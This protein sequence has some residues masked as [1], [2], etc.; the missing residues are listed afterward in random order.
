MYAPVLAAC[1]PRKAPGTHFLRFGW[2][3]H[4]LVRQKL[5]P[6]VKSNQETSS[7]Q[8]GALTTTPQLL[9][10]K[11]SPVKIIY[12]RKTY[13]SVHIDSKNNNDSNNK[14]VR[15][16]QVLAN[17]LV[18]CLI[19]Y[20]HFLFLILYFVGHQTHIKCSVPLQVWEHYNFFF[21]PQRALNLE[22]G[23]LVSV[24]S[25]LFPKIRNM[26]PLLADVTGL[27]PN[28]FAR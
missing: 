28:P 6:S 21:T 11:P 1:F 24:W 23:Q 15:T 27:K 20:V 9:Q 22:L 5:H 18:L 14:F 25:H 2:P 16:L 17:I 3:W 26:H 10:F 4:H 8:V 19:Y 7:Q 13:I 12:L